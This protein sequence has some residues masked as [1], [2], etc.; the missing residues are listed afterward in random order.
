MKFLYILVALCFIQYPVFSQEI[1]KEDCF[2]YTVGI[3]SIK[4]D[5]RNLILAVSKA[6]KITSSQDSFAL[7]LETARL[8]AK[9]KL[10]NNKKNSNLRGV[11]EI[12]N[13]KSENFIYVGLVEKDVE[14]AKKLLSNINESIKST[15]SIR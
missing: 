15:P 6:E 14:T 5:G 7:A 10:A 4:I 9:A 2:K 8:D 1:K 13:C 12:F 3:H 11:R